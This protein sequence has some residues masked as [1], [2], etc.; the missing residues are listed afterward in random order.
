MRI[1]KDT[2]KAIQAARGLLDTDSG[3]VVRGFVGRLD[4]SDRLYVGDVQFDDVDADDPPAFEVSISQIV[5]GVE[6][7]V[8][9]GTHDDGETY[10][11]DQH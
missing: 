9:E 10:T 7:A 11:N 5:G 4:M 6:P 1:T 2:L 8:I 3:Q